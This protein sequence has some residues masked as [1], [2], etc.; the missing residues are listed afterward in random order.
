M[1][2]NVA[3]KDPPMTLGRRQ[4]L[5]QACIPLRVLP[6][7]IVFM[8]RVGDILNKQQL[9]VFVDDILTKLAKEF[10]TIN[11]P[12]PGAWKLTGINEGEDL[13]KWNPNNLDFDTPLFISSSAETYPSITPTAATRQ[14]GSWAWGDGMK[15]I[16]LPLRSVFLLE[17][18]THVLLVLCC[19]TKVKV[20]KKK[21]RTEETNHEVLVPVEYTIS[22]IL[23]L[24]RAGAVN[25]VYHEPYEDDLRH[26]QRSVRQLGWTSGTVLRLELW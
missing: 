10:P 2:L 23:L 8:P 1:A 13:N 21:K 18:D 11:T 6:H 12:K 5:Q 20:A 7:E 4:A 26:D 9:C 19:Q 16:K 24:I 17:G 15:S 22:E 25:G 14:S 3:S